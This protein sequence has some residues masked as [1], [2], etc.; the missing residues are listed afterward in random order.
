MGNPQGSNKVI[1]EV[2][3][4]LQPQKRNMSLVLTYSHRRHFFLQLEPQSFTSSFS[5][6][7]FHD[8]AHPPPPFPPCNLQAPNTPDDTNW[9]CAHLLFSKQFGHKAGWSRQFHYYINSRVTIQ[10]VFV[11]FVKFWTPP[12]SSEKFKT[13]QHLFVGSQST[14]VLLTLSDAI[15]RNQT[16][17][18]WSSLLGALFEVNF[19]PDFKNKY[20]VAK[21][22]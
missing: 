10:R 6:I 15:V 11:D 8:K 17:V 12:F 3:K 21:V 22:L 20:T 9:S 14:G 4:P 7:F 18:T 5:I 13:M 19:L 16:T 2:V 1:I